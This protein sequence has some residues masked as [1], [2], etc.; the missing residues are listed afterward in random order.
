MATIT[1]ERNLIKI[2]YED[3]KTP[4]VFDI[5]TGIMLGLSGQPLRNNPSGMVSVISS[6]C[7]DSNVLHCMHYIHDR[8]GYKYV[9]M[10]RKVHLLAFWDKLDS[11]GYSEMNWYAFGDDKIINFVNKNFKKF[12]KAF[13]ENPALTVTQ[14]KEQ[15]EARIWANEMGIKIDDH[16][17]EPMASV[18]YSWAF[19]SPKK[20][21]CAIYYMKK[22]LIDTV[23]SG[24]ARSLLTNYFQYCDGLEWEYAK[25]DFIRVYAEAKRTYEARKEEIDKLALEK[26]QLRNRNALEFSYGGL[27]VVIPTTRE[28]FHHEAEYQS[29]CVE[30]MYL[31]K[32]LRNETNVVFI[33]R[34]DEPNLPYITC[35]VYK[36][37]IWQYLTRFNN[38]PREEIAEEF[39]N[40]YTRHLNELWVAE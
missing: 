3:K 31:P 38:S 40:A 14:F 34:D 10:S 29:N 9:D 36:G 23:S 13:R 35:E 2:Q 16:F 20:N 18:L 32:V 11:I 12:A 5:S 25:G 21:S 33:R 7:Y 4:Y 27:S 26:N 19:N 15:Y 37:Q 28:E 17:T 39:K 24:T 1:K 22:G 30:R 6:H 8:Y